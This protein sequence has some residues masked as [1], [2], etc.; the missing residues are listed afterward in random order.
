VIRDGDAESSVSPRTTPVV[1]GGE[2]GSVGEALEAVNRSIEDTVE[3][4]EGLEGSSSGVGR[5]WVA[6][7]QQTMPKYGQVLDF[8]QA[9]LT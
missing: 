6:C 9:E 4:T 5:V 7:S 8:L 3:P 2:E 1:R